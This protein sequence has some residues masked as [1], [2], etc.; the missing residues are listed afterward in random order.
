MTTPS[1]CPRAGRWAGAYSPRPLS[2]V[3]GLS[4]TPLAPAGMAA[5][6]PILGALS[7]RCWSGTPVIQRWGR[8]GMVRALPWSFGVFL[9]G[10]VLWA[11]LIPLHPAVYAFAAFMFPGHAIR[12]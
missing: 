6:G 4:V 1:T 12:P 10:P 2:L 8:A 7:R 11:L 9:I 5:A 3:V